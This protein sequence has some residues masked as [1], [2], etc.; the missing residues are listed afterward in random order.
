MLE[1]GVLEVLS[2]PEFEGQEIRYIKYA[3]QV[4]DNIQVAIKSMKKSFESFSEC[5]RLREVQVQP[6]LISRFFDE[7]ESSSYPTTSSYC[8]CIGC[9]SGSLDPQTSS[10]YGINGNKSLSIPQISRKQAP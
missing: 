10:R 7:L 4:T 3:F 1:M 5:L 9:V 2:L 6:P 8:T